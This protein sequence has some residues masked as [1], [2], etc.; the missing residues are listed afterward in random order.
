MRSDII[1]THYLC[2]TSLLT[3]IEKNGIFEIDKTCKVAAGPQRQIKTNT[4][5]KTRAKFS[6][7]AIK[8]EDGSMNV[9]G[10]AVY[11]DDPNSENKA[12]NDATPSGHF[13]MSIA[14]DKEAQ[15]NF[16]EG[17]AEYYFDII[18]VDENAAPVVAST[19]TA[20][21]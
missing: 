10:S 14:K 18:P 1:F 17:T 5:N 2:P 19:D 3:R 21:E 9:S 16:K 8:N 12:F 6:L 20:G 11:S 13:S 4:M 7:T 15:N